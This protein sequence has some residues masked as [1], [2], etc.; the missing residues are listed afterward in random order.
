MD[1][2]SK[3]TTMVIRSNKPIV[4]IQGPNNKGLYSGIIAHMENKSYRIDI[5]TAFCFKTKTDAWKGTR[6]LVKEIKAEKL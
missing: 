3:R 4:S 6:S 1:G 2:I 5:T